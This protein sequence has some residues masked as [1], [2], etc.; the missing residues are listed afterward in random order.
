MYHTTSIF[1]D[2]ACNQTFDR[3]P[4]MHGVLWSAQECDCPAMS[5]LFCMSPLFAINARWE[6]PTLPQ[7]GLVIIIYPPSMTINECY[8]YHPQMIGLWVYGS[9]GFP[10]FSTWSSFSYT[11]K[12]YHLDHAQSRGNWL[13]FPLAQLPSCLRID[14]FSIFAAASADRSSAIG[15]RKASK[16][17]RVELQVVSLHRTATRFFKRICLDLLHS[18]GVSYFAPT[19][20]SQL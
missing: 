11:F 12:R 16:A 1:W 15:V 18:Y 6:V 9:E 14:I 7:L 19:W 8:V 2:W 3:R 10:W 17:L 4:G 5:A 13:G 20:D